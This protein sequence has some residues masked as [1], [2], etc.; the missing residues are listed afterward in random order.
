MAF[1]RLAL[2]EA[3]LRHVTTT[4]VDDDDD[5]RQR[6][7]RQAL[8]V[9]NDLFGGNEENRR[10]L[11]AAID[12]LS[13]RRIRR[14]VA[15]PS[16]RSFY[17]V[18]MENVP[19]AKKYFCMDD[20]CSCADF[21]TAVLNGPPLCKHLLATRLAPYLATLDTLEINDRDYHANLAARFQS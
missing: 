11:D 5:Q 20:F 2:A 3:A 16:Q 8:H 4:A 14:I 12:V 1:D 15:T 9:V 10:L 17:A 7:R 6:I 18:D 21:V 19:Q 13:T